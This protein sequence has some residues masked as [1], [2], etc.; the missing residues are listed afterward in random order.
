MDA[1]EA[2]RPFVERIGEY[3]L[4]LP[5]DLKVLQEAVTD[6]DLDR[7]AREIAAG[8]IIHTL[9]P[10]EGEAGPLRYVDDVLFVRAALQRIV[11]DG[12]EGADALQG[13]FTEIYGK[14]KDDHELFATFLGAV[15]PW[16]TSKIEA[17]AKLPWKGKKSGQYLDDQ[18][19]AASLYEDGLEFETNYPINDE[20][21]KNRV[22]RS[23][24]ILE[25]LKKRQADDAKRKA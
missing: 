21:V 17:F 20:M 2:D 14:L 5:Y 3:L 1:K 22:K 9:M 16:A 12:G 19:S 10:Q 15:W 25:V 18:E 13:R 8:T 11:A 7:K 23:E 24:P 4:S 6:P